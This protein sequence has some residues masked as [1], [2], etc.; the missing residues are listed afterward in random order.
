[1]SVELRLLGPGDA[2]LL[3]RVA[4]DVFDEP[5]SPSRLAAH[6]AEPCHLLLLALESGAGGDLVVGQCAAVIHHH[7]DKPLELYV[8][9]VG[10]AP[11]H[12]GR[13]IGRR[14]MERM[15]EE[16]RARGCEEAWLG[17]EPDNVA[18]QALYRGL[19]GEPPEPFTLY[20]FDLRAP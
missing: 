7:P 3:D 5:V 1:M 9:E 10:V 4:E 16:G 20:A 11:S 6:L 2:H 18:A 15:L 8:D 13:G 12:Q 19:G 14:L 17:T